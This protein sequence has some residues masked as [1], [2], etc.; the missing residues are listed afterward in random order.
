M[1]TQVLGIGYDDIG[2][3]Q[4]L[5]RAMDMVERGGM[6]YAVTPNAEFTLRARKEPRF[7]DALNGADLV[8]PDGIAIMYA[9]RILKRPLSER[10]CGCDFAQALC[11]LLA[12]QGRRLFV[13]GGKPGVA[14]QAG[15][16]LAAANPGLVI[17][18]AQDGYFQHDAAVERAIR[19]ARADVVFVCLGS[20]KQEYWMVEHGLATGAGLL[21]G[22]GGSVDVF[23]NPVKRAP[24]AWRRLGLEWLYRL[25]T[26]P[27]RAGRMARLPLVLLAAV[28]ERVRGSDEDAR[29]AD[30][31]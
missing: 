19:A 8:L 26:Q 18:G 3:E 20:P 28:R 31:V 17:C 12:R 13:L 7:Q 16:N 25:L 24:A 14:E 4:A 9:S 1:R 2:M 23:A 11:P 15:R 21:I 29:K 6:H 22:L 27:F 10:V 30:R 5:E